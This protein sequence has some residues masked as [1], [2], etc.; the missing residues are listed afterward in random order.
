MR[1][2]MEM[3]GPEFVPL[4]AEDEIWVPD[5]NGDLVRLEVSDDVEDDPT[6]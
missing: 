1:K 2:S 4:D 3:Q 5:E 6:K